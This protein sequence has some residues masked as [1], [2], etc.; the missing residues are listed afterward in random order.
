MSDDLVLDLYT[1]LETRVVAAWPDIVSST[2]DVPTDGVQ[3]AE[4]LAEVTFKSR[5]TPFAIVHFPEMEKLRMGFGN[6]DFETDIEIYYITDS[7]RE[8][9]EQEIKQ[10][11]IDL[12]VY[13]DDV[14]ND[15][16]DEENVGQ[17]VEIARV[18]WSRH[19][20]INEEFLARNM[21]HLAGLVVIKIW[22]GR[23]LQPA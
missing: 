7:N 20:T 15:F 13:L 17:I 12:A 22:T 3:H 11:V 8:T 23:V 1:A 9:H 16:T 2:S 10:H 4:Q 18:S 19:L 14:D 5:E 21:P 6:T